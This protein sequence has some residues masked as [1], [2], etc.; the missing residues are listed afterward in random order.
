MKSLVQLILFSLI[1]LNF[2]CTNY[3]VTKN[4]T[5]PPILIAIK[6][7]GNGHLV[8]IRANNPEAFFV[9]YRLYI[10][11]SE[12]EAR[13]PSDLNTGI[14]CASGLTAIPNQPAE[15]YLD[16]AQD[17]TNSTSNPICRFSFKA[18][19]GQYIAVRGLLLSIQPSSQ[20]DR[21]SYSQPS[22]ALIVP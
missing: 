21:V 1:S 2:V 5:I 3:S 12:K 18:S 14:D 4:K 11:N 9:G 19:S 7:S 13:N 16:I 8:S 17:T 20:T 15:Y 10:G 22:N 6:S